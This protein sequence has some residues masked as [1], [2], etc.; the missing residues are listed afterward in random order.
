MITWTLWSL[1]W[2]SAT[3][4]WGMVKH[5]V[6]TTEQACKRQQEYVISVPPPHSVTQAATVCKLSIDT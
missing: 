6:H 1:L 3:G 5:G 2:L 4:E